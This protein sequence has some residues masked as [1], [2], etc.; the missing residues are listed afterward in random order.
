MTTASHHSGAR[1][2]GDNHLGGDDWDQR[3]VS[4]LIDQVE[5]RRRPVQGRQSPSSAPEERRAAKERLR[6]PRT[7]LQ[8]LSTTADGPIH[9]DRDPHARQVRN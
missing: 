3:I 5:P 6:P 2:L 4:W 8:Y 9:L 1:H 7:S